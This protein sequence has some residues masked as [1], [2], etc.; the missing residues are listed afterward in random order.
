M[1][2]VLSKYSVRVYKENTNFRDVSVKDF[3]MSNF[4]DLVAQCQLYCGA[5][6][7]KKD[8]ESVI[9]DN[10]VM[11]FKTF[12]LMNYAVT[13]EEYISDDT[14]KNAFISLMNLATDAL[15]I[16]YVIDNS[17]TP[18]N[19]SDYFEKLNSSYLADPEVKRIFAANE[20]TLNYSFVSALDS[21]LFF[22]KI[23]KSNK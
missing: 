15:S 21:V 17:E 22:R 8:V 2:L 19:V 10:M 1:A 5:T 20:K 6:P 11:L 23:T 16:Q 3:L 7:T 4:S 18:K 13:L 14:D 12:S 9:D